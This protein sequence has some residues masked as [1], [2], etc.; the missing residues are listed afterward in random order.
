ML[1]LKI[2]LIALGAFLLLLYIGSLIAA[3]A[4]FSRND[5]VQNNLEKALEISAYKYLKEDILAAR[6]WA[7]QQKTE[8]VV[9][10]SYDGLRLVGDYLP[11]ENARGTI[12]LFHGW[13]GGTVA[14]FGVTLQ[15]YTGLGLNVLL[16]HQ[17]AQGKSSGRFI[18]FG[19][20]ERRDVHSWV[21]WHNE[22]FGADKPVWIAG[23]SM[24][25]TTVLMACGEP[26]PE[27]MRGVLA[28]C[29][30]TAPNDIISAVSRSMH[31]PP[32]LLVPLIGI[33]SRVFAGFGLKEY[34]TIDAMKQTTLPI[35][36]AHGESDAF[37]PCEM[38]KRNYAACASRDKTLLLVAEAGH[39]QCYPK[40]PER[41]RAAVRD[42]I[43]RTIA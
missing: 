2:I 14:D 20:K 1:A 13:R 10:Y 28:D 34:S 32:P 4:A 39:G 16:V 9:I 6:D 43:E 38:T 15:Y 22:R 41:Y 24:G 33:H 36:F 29:G 31:V 12:L 5:F 19:I 26:F 21:Q 18:T 17:R 42:F 23:L 30:F 37:V 11:T 27:N 7:L 25:A 40:Q 8:E 3:Y 35:L